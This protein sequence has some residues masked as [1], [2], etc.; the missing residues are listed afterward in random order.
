MVCHVLRIRLYKK[1]LDA[2]SVCVGLN[3]FIRVEENFAS[4]KLTFKVRYVI[5]VTRG[6]FWLNMLDDIVALLFSLLHQRVLYTF[7]K[8]IK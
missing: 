1:V 2:D 7:L 5:Y 3:C 8:Q 4:S 6:L